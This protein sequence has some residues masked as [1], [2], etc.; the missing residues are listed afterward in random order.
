[1]IKLKEPITPK[2]IDSFSKKIITM[3]GK[4]ELVAEKGVFVINIDYSFREVIRKMHDVKLI[5][6]I[7]VKRR[8][9]PV[10]RTS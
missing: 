8:K 10:A 3:G 6:G 2:K 7:N 9:I 5:G 4:I 1:L